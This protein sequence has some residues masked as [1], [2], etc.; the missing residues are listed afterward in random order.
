MRF[1]YFIYFSLSV[2][3][4]YGTAQSFP[5][6]AKYGVSSIF[7]HND[8]DQALPFYAAYN[9]RVGYIEVDIFLQEDRLL[10]AHHFMDLNVSRNLEQMY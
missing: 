6:A 1:F 10:V 7:A 5:S 9:Y 2:W 3:I 4:T 8:Y